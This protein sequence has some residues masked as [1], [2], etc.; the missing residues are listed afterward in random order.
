MGI[1]S[2]DA[3]L[4]EDFCGEVRLFP[5]PNVVLFPNVV[6]A[7]HIFEP[8]YCDMLEEALATDRLITMASF[9]PGWESHYLGSPALADEVCIGKIL[10]HTR[11]SDDR[12]NILLAGV[13]RARLVREIPT[14]LAFRRAEVIVLEDV[15]PEDT[16]GAVCLRDELLTLLGHAFGES[17]RESLSQ[18]FTK[19]LP[20]GVLTD[21]IA[22]SS[23]IPIDKKI[24]LLGQVRVECRC[25]VLLQFLRQQANGEM[26]AKSEPPSVSPENRFPP[27]F[28]QN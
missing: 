24:E 22:F 6:Q 19:Q 20:L 16:A 27:P 12:H 13:K 21:V 9:K 3:S 7:L 28:S 25:R 4:P 5:L 11:T 15:Y 14:S 10:T 23:K 26:S 1:P 18:L 2:F 8:R 17:A